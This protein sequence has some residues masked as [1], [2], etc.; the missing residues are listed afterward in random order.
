MLCEAE[1]PWLLP[2]LCEVVA[3]AAEPWENE[4]SENTS[5]DES[6]LFTPERD[7]STGI[8]GCGGNCLVEDA[9]GL[10][11]LTC[12]FGCRRLNPS[13]PESLSNDP[14]D[15]NEERSEDV[16]EPAV[17]REPGPDPSPCLSGLS[18]S[19]F[20]LKNM[21]SVLWPGA[22]LPVACALPAAC[23]LPLLPVFFFFF[24]KLNIAA[25]WPLL[26]VIS[27]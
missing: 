25:R 6:V 17:R 14:C 9:T 5:S 1:P 4:L 12:F 7:L 23:A 26:C 27:R 18:G 24:V 21:L 15:W 2:K 19:F 3:V 22:A 10:K 16:L 11:F 8:I 13:F 20:T